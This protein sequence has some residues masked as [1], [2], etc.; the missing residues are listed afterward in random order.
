MEIRGEIKAA[1]LEVLKSLNVDEKEII[2]S[3]DLS[4]ADFSTNVAMTTFHKLKEKFKNPLE[5]AEYIANQ[6]QKKVPNIDKIEALAPGFINFFLSREY[7]ISQL[8]H[9]ASS[10]NYGIGSSLKSQKI[11][12]EFADPNPFKEFHIGHLRNIAL[13]ESFARLMEFQGAELLRAN[14][15]GDVGMHVAKAIYGIYH[16]PLT[17]DDFKKLKHEGKIKS[18]GKAYATGAKAYEE[19]EKAKKEIAEIN[20]KLYAGSDPDLNKL[21]E[22]GRKWSLEHF[23]GIYKRLGTKYDKYYFESQTAEPG[24]KIVLANID[25]GIFEKHEGAMVFRGNHTRVFVTS[26]DLPA[27]R[28]GYAT[29]E[30]KDL[31]LAKLKYEDFKYDSS[32]VITA[33]EQEP[34][35]KVVLEAME[36]VLPELA[37]KTTHYAFGFV[38][39]KDG[40]MSS[41]SGNVVAGEWLLNEARK[42]LKSQFK[43][44]DE[45]TLE[46]VAVGAVKYSML[47]F[48]RKSD[49]T[50][51]FEESISLE[52]NSG[53]YIQYTYAR[54]R[55][56]LAK[57]TNS[58]SQ[59]PNKSKIQNT[60][61]E[62]EELLVLRLL[63]QFP[64]IV[65]DAQ[66]NFSPN[67]L[68]NYLFELSQAFNNFYQKHK[69]VGSEKEEFRLE[70]ASG[71]G[72]ILS[73][74][75]YLLGIEAPQKM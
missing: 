31:A 26:E 57:I 60:K 55:S 2:F 22:E 65:K 16:L 74:G 71:V 61:L 29:Y 9:I 64:E 49:I 24:R 6:L 38:N 43:R 63:I 70:L 56:V 7:L 39:L 25:N 33:S 50:F 5:L 1:V 20:L 51:S 17:I 30:A 34:Y 59:I 13:G 35:F 73:T 28:Q 27:G 32:I 62:K 54:T 58:K 42:R 3:S 14:Y 53:P 44:M 46:K 72:Q 4:H 8:D 66:E 18:L 69:V 40:K 47:K 52:G 19:D 75:L 36:K 67:T 10:K 48:S 37:K 45:E 21:W 68:A 11:M 15:Q 12:L 23:E 41:R